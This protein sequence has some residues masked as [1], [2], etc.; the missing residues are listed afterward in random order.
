MSL[1]VHPSF[2]TLFMRVALE[3]RLNRVKLSLRD[4]LAKVTC[5]RALGRLLMK[6][7]VMRLSII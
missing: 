2:S 5:W 1:P 7:K 6:V 4:I 3:S